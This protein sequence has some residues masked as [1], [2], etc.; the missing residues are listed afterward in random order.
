MRYI[1]K[2]AILAVVLALLAP[3]AV[4]LADYISDA[5][6]ALQKTSVYVAPGTEGT[7]KDTAGRLQTRL[8]KDDNIVLVM[9]P[10]T[11]ETELGTDI[12]TIATRLSEELGNKRII[13]L[14]VGNN[15]VGYA[16]PPTLPV[17]VAADK[18]RRARSVSNDPI[19]ALGTFAQNMHTWQAEN[20]TP[21][22]SPLESV[23]NGGLSWIWWLVIGVSSFFVFGIA[24]VAI[25]NAV[26]PANSERIHFN[27]PDQ[28]KDL[29]D[30]IAKARWQV[31]DSTLQQT[32]YQLC[33]D[34]EKYFAVP[35]EA[36]KRDAVH[37][38][39]RLTDV[40][41]VLEKYIDVQQNPRYYRQSQAELL[42]GKE[43]IKDFSDY[44][45]QVIQDGNAVSLVDYTVNTNILLAERFRR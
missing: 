39:N 21:Q 41:Q 4:A 43:S 16:P 1:V 38:K 6:Q 11:A 31:R 19:T 35:S 7:D 17:G 40:D 9:L 23:K 26:A 25:H 36:K 30:K 34:V 44:V 45:L 10:S 27:A 14:A 5:A 37:F 29:L 28:V 22:P 32:V 20:P 12:T 42:K 13:G 3:S 15:V 33:L 2:V 18:M 24:V 8:N